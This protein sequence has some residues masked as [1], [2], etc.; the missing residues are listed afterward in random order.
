MMIRKSGNFTTKKDDSVRSV[1]SRHSTL[2]GQGPTKSSV[3][4]KTFISSFVKKKEEQF[5]P[6]LAD[7]KIKV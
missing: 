3:N 6:L 4:I 2:D 5:M 1:I 7:L